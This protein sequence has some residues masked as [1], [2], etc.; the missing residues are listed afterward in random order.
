[1]LQKAQE[2]KK[3]VQHCSTMQTLQMAKTS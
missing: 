2:N 1:M 3:Y